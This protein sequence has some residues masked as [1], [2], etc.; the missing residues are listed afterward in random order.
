MLLKKQRIL[1][2]EH[3]SVLSKKFLAKVKANVMCALSR[4]NVKF[5]ALISKSETNSKFECS[6]DTNDQR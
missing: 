2:F 4:K 5:E 6:N 3:N 1:S